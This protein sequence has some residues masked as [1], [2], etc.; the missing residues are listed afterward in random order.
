ME[1][2]SDTLHD[3]GKML[4]HLADTIRNDGGDELIES[5]YKLLYTLAAYQN[6]MQTD[7]F[8]ISANAMLLKLRKLEDDLS[9]SNTIIRTQATAIQSK[10]RIIRDMESY[11]DEIVDGYKFEI[12]QERNRYTEL[13]AEFKDRGMQIT[14]LETKLHNLKANQADMVKN[15]EFKKDCEINALKQKLLE[16][17]NEISTLKDCAAF[18]KG[19][20]KRQADKTNYWMDKA[21]KA[22]KELAMYKTSYGDVM[23]LPDG[24]SCPWP[25]AKI[26][27]Q[28]YFAINGKRYTLWGKG[29]LI[30]HGYCTE[31]KS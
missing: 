31:N 23:L 19:R 20:I 16:A 18:D 14:S 6:K 7:S 21:N 24:I 22:E 15:A 30:Y 12:E 4:T 5:R 3:F 28:H 29:Y 1:R 13:L 25:D 11:H 17:N 26:I 27:D 2:L 8:S 10:D 9:T